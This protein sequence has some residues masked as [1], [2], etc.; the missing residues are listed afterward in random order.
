MPRTKPKLTPALRTNGSAE[1]VLTLAETAAYLRLT[2]AEVLR[3]VREQDLPARQVGSEWR[4]L[5]SAIDD[6]LRTGP[7][8]RSNREAWAAL[9]GN[10]EGR[11]DAGRTA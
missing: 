2:T 8:T 4:L 10:L 3:M 7:P 1:P 6:W 9:A 11:R 5:R